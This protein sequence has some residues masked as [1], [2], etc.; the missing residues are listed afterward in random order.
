L[1]DRVTFVEADYRALPWEDG[2]VDAACALESAC[3]A[4][5]AGKS[6]FLAEAARV[7]KPGG[8]LVV[9]DGFRKGATMNAIVRRCY[10]TMC[11]CWKV[12]GCAEI[13]AFTRAA[14]AAGFDQIR[15]EEIS[16]RVAPSVAFVPLVS[17]G[18]LWRECVLRGG[19]LTRP[20]WE[21][22]LAS[23]LGVVVGAA[24]STFGYY[25]VSARKAQG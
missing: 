1:D 17:A 18:F 11:R 2:S 12:E 3:H 21:N 14:R 22:V 5:G 6:D 16:W 20:R 23:L 4:D 9:A 13:G 24:R 7:L 10:E 25:L 19:T 8:W 15:V